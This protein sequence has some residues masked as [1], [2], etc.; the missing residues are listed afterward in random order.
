MTKDLVHSPFLH[1]LG[2][3]LRN[4]LIQADRHQHQPGWP[5]IGLEKDDQCVGASDLMLEYKHH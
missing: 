3:A 4:G 1:V 5:C 2:S